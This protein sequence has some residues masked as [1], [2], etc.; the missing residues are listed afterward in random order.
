MTGREIENSR[1]K[2][3]YSSRDINRE[4][5][6]RSYERERERERKRERL[7]KPESTR[8]TDRTF[9]YLLC[10]QSEAEALGRRAGDFPEG[11]SS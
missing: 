8:S 1:E 2:A 6:E 3:L 7:G 4:D 5:L 9:A 11:Q 10:Q